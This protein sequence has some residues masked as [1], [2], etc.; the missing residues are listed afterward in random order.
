MRART[1]IHCFG[2]L[3]AAAVVAV[4]G[5][6]ITA[7][8]LKKDPASVHTILPVTSL[9]LWGKLNTEWP[10]WTGGM[11]KEDST[12]VPEEKPVVTVTLNNGSEIEGTLVSEEE[13][14]ILL[15]VEGSQ[16]GFHASEIREMHKKG[17]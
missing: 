8:L 15:D 16:V 14:W 10:K 12:E 7:S 3:T 9:P 17:A 2:L 11:P 4:A 6:R 5:E 1:L 13:D